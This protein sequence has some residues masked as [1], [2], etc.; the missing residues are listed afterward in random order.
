MKPHNERYAMELIIAKVKNGDVAAFNVLVDEHKA[1]AFTL[2]LRLL[3]SR[4][5]AEEVTQDSFLK[6]YKNIGQFKEEAKFSTWLYTIVYNT[7]LTSLRKKKLKTTEI[8]DL[9][10]ENL[11][12]LSE[13]DAE[14]RRLQK[15][16][17]SGYI[18]LALTQLSNDDQ[19]AITLFYLNENSLQE[20]CEITNW[21]LSNVKVRLHR[22]RKRL[23][24]ALEHLLDNEVRELL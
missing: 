16:E 6:A 18:Q 7:A 14:W 11:L 8:E 19:V 12:Q 2:A 23:L 5:D 9:S 24:I 15:E 3:K 22:A 21:E 4:E 17:R 13:P 20:I 1:M 10:S